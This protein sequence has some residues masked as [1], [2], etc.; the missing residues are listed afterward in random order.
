MAKIDVKAL[1]GSDRKDEAEA[2][3]A[4]KRE[5]LESVKRYPKDTPKEFEEINWE[6]F[7]D[8]L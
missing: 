5:I 3:S 4:D 6:D 8:S 1:I 7:E 2:E